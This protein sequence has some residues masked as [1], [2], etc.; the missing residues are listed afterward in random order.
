[1]GFN[2]DRHLKVA[3]LATV[4]PGHSFATK[5]NFLT[6]FNTCGNTNGVLLPVNFHGERCSLERL[7]ESD[8]R[9]RDSVGAF[10]WTWRG[11]TKAGTSP[12]VRLRATGIEA[13]GRST[14]HSEEILDIDSRTGS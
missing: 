4:F 1:M 14:E 8:R 12:I 9:R 13:T 6:F 3:G 5:A 7:T 2:V 11:V 10:P